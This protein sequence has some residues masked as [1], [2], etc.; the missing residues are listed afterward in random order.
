[1]ADV[2]LHDGNPLN[3]EDVYDF[4]FPC[5][6]TATAPP[7]RVYPDGHPYEKLSQGEMY[8]EALQ[9]EPA[10]VVPRLGVIR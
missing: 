5:V 3:V 4:K 10:R 7:W 6:N 9:V 2:V 8:E 1:M